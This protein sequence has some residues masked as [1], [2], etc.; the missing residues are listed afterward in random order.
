MKIYQKID[1][2]IFEQC[3]E[4]KNAQPYQKFIEFLGQIQDQKKQLYAALATIAFF[5][6]PL[7]FT[8]VI[9]FLIINISKTIEIKENIQVAL[10]QVTQIQT[11]HSLLSNQLKTPLNLSSGASNVAE[12]INSGSDFSAY[13]ERTSWSNLNSIA[14]Y[15]DTEENELELNINSLST[16]EAMEVTEKVILQGK[17]IIDEINLK[18]NNETRLLNGKIKF[19]VF[20]NFTSGIDS[21]E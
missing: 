7:T 15:S 6:I 13:S 8:I 18:R 12:V 1:Q 9:I 2:F 10:G 3:E 14:T 21:G 20:T 17:F 4:L 19:I 11:Q 16:L 5:L